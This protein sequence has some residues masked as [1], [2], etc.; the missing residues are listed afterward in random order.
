MQ[1]AKCIYNPKPSHVHLSVKWIDFTTLPCFTK[2]VTTPYSPNM[3]FCSLYSECTPLLSDVS[4]EKTH[5][6]CSH[7]FNKKPVTQNYS[8]VNILLTSK[9]V[10][11]QETYFLTA[12]ETLYITSSLYRFPQ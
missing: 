11:H 10:K 3:D 6:V 9:E 2:Q 1:Y 7:F 5:H 8:Y 4:S 12:N